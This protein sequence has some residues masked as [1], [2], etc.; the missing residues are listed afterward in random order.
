MI[1]SLIKYSVMQNT[2]LLLT[3]LNF[4]YNIVVKLLHNICM[5]QLTHLHIP[6]MLLNLVTSS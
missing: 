5:K 6:D 1:A 3:Q 2:Y 4:I